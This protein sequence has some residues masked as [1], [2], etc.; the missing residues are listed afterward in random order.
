[1]Q[2][3]DEMNDKYG[4]GDGGCYPAG[5][6][7]YRDIY[8]KTVSRLA[9]YL[10]SDYRVVPYNRC[11]VHNYCLWYFV[12]KNWFETVY[13]PMQEPEKQWSAVTETEI[14]AAESE[15]F[16]NTDYMMAAAVEL[17]RELDIDQ[18]VNIQV[19][20]S[21]SFGEFLNDCHQ[22]VIRLQLA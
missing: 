1:M 7:T 12:S 5:I 4:F 2:Y 15:F 10:E 8:V 16:E 11:G 19:D 21:P 6:E 18:Y 3:W 17:A 22:E 14:Q 20:L 13:L 9:E